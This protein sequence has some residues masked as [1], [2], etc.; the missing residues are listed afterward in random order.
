MGSEMCIRDRIND[1]NVIIDEDIYL[2]H[3]TIDGTTYLVHALT[4]QGG[5]LPLGKD[6][7]SSHR[8]LFTLNAIVAL[9]LA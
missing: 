2:D 3:V 6:S 1:I 7:P 5:I 9:R 8:S 4:R